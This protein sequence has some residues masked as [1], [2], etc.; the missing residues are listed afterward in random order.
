MEP[1]FQTSFIPKKSVSSAPQPSYAKPTSNIL[2]TIS[3]VLFVGTILLSAGL[4]FY[5]QYLKS[6]IS[7][8]NAEITK[9][10][11]D[12]Q[13][14]TIEELLGHNDR[15]SFATRILNNHIV[16]YPM[17]A[18]L[19]S[20]ILKNVSFTNLSYSNKDGVISL[21]SEVIAKNYNAIAKQSVDFTKSK[22][23]SN[24]VFSGFKLTEQ[25]TIFARFTMNLDP[26]L[27]SY[28]KNLE[29]SNTNQ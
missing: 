22:Y 5:Q 4:F 6:Q 7:A 2:Y 19:Q 17:F 20:L 21:S 29:S 15:I 24:S 16:L 23:I 27:V 8:A 14:P 28:R 3:V 10:R 18:E 13:I 9:T 12:F 26:S 25:G 11:A 1:K